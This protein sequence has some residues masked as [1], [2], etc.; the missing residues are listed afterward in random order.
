MIEIQGN[1]TYHVWKGTRGVSPGSIIFVD[2]MNITENVP[3]NEWVYLKYDGFYTN[4]GCIHKCPT[5]RIDRII[6][7]S[8]PGMVF[9]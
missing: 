4:S 5:N 9:A 3:K 8:G 6:A 7:T 2:G 1:L